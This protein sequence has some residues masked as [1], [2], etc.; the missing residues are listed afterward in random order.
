MS[1][2]IFDFPFCWASVRMRVPA[3]RSSTPASL[4]ISG[5]GLVAFCVAA[6]SD[7]LF[8]QRIPA[9]RRLAAGYCP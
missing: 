7:V 6:V 2:G 9:K 4:Q 3:E 8:A 1:S 5:L